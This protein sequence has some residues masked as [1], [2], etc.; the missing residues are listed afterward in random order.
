M[1]ME[2]VQTY[3]VEAA[4]I[5]F[6]DPK[7]PKRGKLQA[8]KVGKFEHAFYGDI[9]FTERRFENFK[10]NFDTRVRGIDI[11]IDYDHKM[12]PAKGAKAAGWLSEIT[13]DKEAMYFTIDF[14]DDAMASIKKG[15]Y[16]Y[17]SAEVM[18]KWR[19]ASG[20]D[21]EDVISGGGLT[22]RPFIKGMAP[23]NLSEFAW[24]GVR[25][26]ETPPNKEDGMDKKLLDALRKRYNLSEDAS[27]ADVLTALE[28]D[29]D[30]EDGSEELSEAE[31][32][33]NKV[34]EALGLSATATEAEITKKLSEQG[35]SG[36]NDEQ[37][38]ALAE[39]N[40]V[41]PV[42]AKMFSDQQK[43]LESTMQ[44]SKLNAAAAHLS[45]VNRRLS[46]YEQ[47]DQI[48]PPVVLNEA[49]ASLL[50]PNTTEAQAK[51]IYS[52][53]D[54][55]K[56]NAGVTLG[57]IGGGNDPERLNESD[58]AVALDKAVTKLQEAD[59]KLSYREAIAK[60]QVTN[61]QLVNN[62]TNSVVPR[63]EV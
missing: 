27:E 41:N 63:V 18:D 2:Q 50:D 6:S 23:I 36:G 32:T 38:Q 21:F 54:S 9:E 60:L 20:K 39:L 47:G 4:G 43:M 5:T 28:A 31:Q 25:L 46:D 61:P 48:V 53:L 57:E 33:L 58:P 26:S 17:F 16:R 10:K 24:T 1:T 30:E 34:R 45:E 11:D 35:G 15:E 55:I 37:A 51:R 52:M 19:D 3:L 44:Q 42:L 56:Q 29:E 62:Y 40:K 8:L 49:K 22:N 12:D 14:T 13:H 59:P 7:N